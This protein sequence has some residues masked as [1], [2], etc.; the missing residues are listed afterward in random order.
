MFVRRFLMKRLL[1][2]AAVSF[3]SGISSGEAL[4]DLAFVPT[5]GRVTS[6]NVS[7]GRRAVLSGWNYPASGLIA[8]DP[9][10]GGIYLADQND[11]A[12]YRINRTNGAVT[13]L[14]GPGIGS[15]PALTMN[16]YGIVAET[17]GNAV[18]VD[19]KDGLLGLVRVDASTGNR[20]VLSA[21]SNSDAPAGSGANFSSPFAIAV[22]RNGH[23]LVT[24]LDRNAVIIVDRASGNRTTVSGDPFGDNVGSGP[25]MSSPYGIAVRSDGTIFVRD[26]S[27]F[28]RIDPTTGNRTAIPTGSASTQG[29]TIFSL[30]MTTNS[31]VV[32]PF[33]QT[34]NSYPI[35]ATVWGLN[36]S[37][38]AVS[39]MSGISNVFLSAVTVRGSGPM[40]Y[41][42]IGSTVDKT[43]M[44]V[45][46]DVI[47]RSLF[48]IDQTTGNRSVLTNSRS[49]QGVDFYNATGVAF[50]TNGSL[51]IADSG[52]TQIY[53]IPGVSSTNDREPRILQV[54]TASGNRTVLSAGSNTSSQR[55]SGANFDQPLGIARESAG[56]L[57]VI[58]NG[59]AAGSRILR[60]DP[61]TG[62]R[63]VVSSG[64]VGA[65][66]KLQS[67]FSISVETAGT[68][69]VTDRLLHAVVRIDPT[70][71]NRMILSGPSQGTGP[72]FQQPDGIVILDGSAAAVA[73]PYV[74]AILRVNLTSG[75]RSI[76]SDISHGGGAMF[77]SPVGLA[78]GANGKLI[79]SDTTKMS[80]IEVDVATG[81]RTLITDVETGSGP[82]FADVPQFLAVL[83]SPVITTMQP[84]AGHFQFSFTGSTGTSYS[85]YSSTNLTAWNLLTNISSG[86]STNSITD[87]NSLLG[88]RFFRVTSP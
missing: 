39:I 66:T 31:L 60:V 81:D 61:A 22:D 53:W 28:L 47:S 5:A 64:S 62:N 79:V 77:A 86:Q 58:D 69:L 88:R 35:G 26:S 37:N 12:V 16:L 33:V 21:G 65:G 29:S 84:T 52:D 44:I 78:F 50:L 27:Q 75:D 59:A 18:V 25:A 83:P 24:D 43:G 11:Q 30:A 45:A 14:S 54:D 76:L 23:L 42:L 13:L 17:N 19:G 71:G 15:G 4:A 63:S 51:A 40:F 49:G 48:L 87:T 10:T 72:S 20:S 32:A 3:V 70:T 8:T 41:Q 1:V 36:G 57:L 7:N 67:P 73:D 38:G 6:V 34:I 74:N 46:S 85:V 2:I 80:L 56:T 68:A 55:G 9:L 82:L